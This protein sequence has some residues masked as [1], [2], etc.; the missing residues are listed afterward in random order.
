[1]GVSDEVILDL[2]QLFVV[3]VDIL[4]IFVNFG[5]DIKELVSPLASPFSAMSLV[6]GQYYGIT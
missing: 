5:F 6:N 4:V 3:F 1:V 2:V